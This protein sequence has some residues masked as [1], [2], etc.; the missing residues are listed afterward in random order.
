LIPIARDMHVAIASTTVLVAALYVVS[1]V[2][3]PTLG[4][5]ADEVGARSVFLAGVLLVG[6]AGLTGALAQSLTVLLVSR[7]LLGLGTSACYPAAMVLVRQRAGQAIP[8]RLLGALSISGQVS[9]A[10][11]LPLGG[12]LVSGFGWRSTFAINVPLAAIT[13][14]L[15]ATG[16]HPN[17]DA[18]RS[19]DIRRLASRLD[20]V[21]AALFCAAISGWFETLRRV[22]A[23]WSPVLVMLTA[24]GTIAFVAWECVADAPLIDVRGLPA[25]RP[26]LLTYMRSAVAFLVIY[27]FMYSITQWLEEGRHLSSAQAALVLLPMSVV[28][29]LVSIPSARTMRLRRSILFSSALYVAALGA[30]LI[31]GSHT[32]MA[33]ILAVVVA[34]GVA[35][36]VSLIANQAALYLQA[37]PKE[38]GAAAGLMRS[39][40]YVGA[41]VSSA[42][43][44]VTFGRLGAGDAGLHGVTAVLAGAAVLMLVGITIDRSLRTN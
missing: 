38:I 13:L 34:F 25:N 44:T 5:L 41:V 12:L 2:A 17:P 33:L 27:G 18:V 3:Q 35:I 6:V 8:G 7:I 26:L 23:G 14:L 30:L 36:G 16:T 37:S 39:A 11:G 29:A 24:V 31:T 21:G 10:V 4:R 9:A 15:A 20:V 28:S 40:N 22:G 1:A 43:I 42:I 32:P 19:V